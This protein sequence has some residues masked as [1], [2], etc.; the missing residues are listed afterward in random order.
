MTPGRIRPAPW[1]SR[2]GEAP[3]PRVLLPSVGTATQCACTPGVAHTDSMCGILCADS[4]CPPISTSGYTTYI[5]I[6]LFFPML[7]HLC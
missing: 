5:R 7:L 1:R 6:D 3:S 4:D 2:P